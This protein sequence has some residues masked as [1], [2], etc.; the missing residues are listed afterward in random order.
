MADSLTTHSNGRRSCGRR[1]KG[2]SHRGSPAP[3][4]ARAHGR[5]RGL[6]GGT[7]G[8]VQV[9]RVFRRDVLAGVLQ[10]AQ[11]ARRRLHG[12]ARPRR[13]QAHHGVHRPRR[14]QRLQV[15]GGGAA[16]EGQGEAM[17][18]GVHGRHGGGAA[19]GATARDGED[20][21]HADSRGKNARGR[22]LLHAR[23]HG[24]PRREH[25]IFRPQ[26]QRHAVEGRVDLPRVQGDRERG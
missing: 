13:V 6:R 16:G 23:R 24:A 12:Q 22:A 21:R 14:H 7:A 3:A 17:E 8:Q 20:R 5:V 18:A 19:I 9:P 10:I 4:P 25:H 15:P 1:S 26:T 11:D 2:G